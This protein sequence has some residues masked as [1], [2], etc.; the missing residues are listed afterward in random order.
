MELNVADHTLLRWQL[1]KAT[2]D[3]APELASDFL[4]SSNSSASNS[5]LEIETWMLDTSTQLGTEIL[6][7]PDW[8]ATKVKRLD[9]GYDV[10]HRY[11]RLTPQARNAITSFIRY[12]NSESEF[13]W[14]LFFIGAPYRSLR[15]KLF[16]LITSEQ[17]PLII[18]RRNESNEVPSEQS[19]QSRLNAERVLHPPGS[20]MPNV[21]LDESS[22]STR[23]GRLLSHADQVFEIPNG[24]R[25][26]L[27][28]VRPRVSFADRPGRDL[29]TKPGVTANNP[30]SEPEKG[31]QIRTIETQKN[32]KKY[33]QRPRDYS[34]EIIEIV[35][36]DDPNRSIGRGSD[37]TEEIII[38]REDT[39]PRNRTYPRN[40]G[41]VGEQRVIEEMNMSRPQMY[42]RSSR[43]SD[44]DASSM[45]RI[46]RRDTA[47]SQ[48]RYRSRV[49]RDRSRE[50]S[51]GLKMMIRSDDALKQRRPRRQM[52]RNS[53]E[54][55]DVIL[56]NPPSRRQDE[57]KL[58]SL[59]EAKMEATNSHKAGELFARRTGR[60]M[61][62]E[63]SEE[64]LRPFLRTNS[65]QRDS[66]VLPD[67]D[68]R[69]RRR[70]TRD[71]VDER[72]FS[73]RSTAPQFD[74]RD[75][76]SGEGLR[77]AEDNRALV[78]YEGGSRAGKSPFERS[79]AGKRIR[80]W[81]SDEDGS[82]SARIQIVSRDRI[83]YQTGRTWASLP[84]RNLSVM[85]EG[86]ASSE[87]D[88]DPFHDLASGKAALTSRVPELSDDELITQTLKRY[89]TFTGDEIPGASLAAS[90]GLQPTT[91]H[92]AEAGSVHNPRAGLDKE[93]SSLKSVN[94]PDQLT[95]RLDTLS[96]TEPDIPTTQIF[97]SPPGRSYTRVDSPSKAARQAQSDHDEIETDINNHIRDQNVPATEI[98]KH[99]MKSSSQRSSK[100]LR[101]LDSNNRVVE[102]ETSSLK[103][104]DKKAIPPNARWTKVDRKLVSPEALIWGNERFEE[105]EDYL[106]VLR[107][108]TREEIERYA[109]K[110]IEIKKETNID[111]SN[112]E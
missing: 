24:R 104:A 5:S 89:T 34:D 80:T 76:A 41:P 53:R 68:R 54:H 60:A 62:K 109:L 37:R 50:D 45:L 9:K 21:S 67:R 59:D 25:D 81:E 75:Y 106:V 95:G 101:K 38:R 26:S 58:L 66:L 79:R 40:H 88:Y 7:A 82:P 99:S 36:R 78:L 23:P 43:E 90:A 92:V 93:S 55:T 65:N 87:D 84:G 86:D 94:N 61:S 49:N 73:R 11:G 18:Y 44:S 2:R 39:L 10:W 107:V 27:Q 102:E 17:M 31:E 52:N 100:E 98:E 1:R 105:R 64:R 4:L 71:S 20:A 110:T 83:P 35:P 28:L 69:S 16:G 6:P 72:T 97:S 15:S 103:D 14:G 112:N 96:A 3:R 46:R 63:R 91:G 19:S 47:E 12:K 32:T 108:L 8:L 111:R 56:R 13:E 29:I 57:G 33:G 85:H 77:N 22:T 70:E 74:H 30:K 51:D 42:R 48:S